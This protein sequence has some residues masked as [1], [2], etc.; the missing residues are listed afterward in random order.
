MAEQ[1]KKL[2]PKAKAALEQY[3]T[4]RPRLERGA[5]WGGSAALLTSVTGDKGRKVRLPATLAATAG[6]MADHRLQEFAKKNREAARIAGDTFDKSAS[7]PTE[8]MTTGGRSRA[9]EA[10]KLAQTL[11][12]NKAVIAARAREQLA[13][14]FPEGGSTDFSGGKSQFIVE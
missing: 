5:K 3:S 2:S 9:V 6:G 7:C 10:A 8:H 12:S 14:L 11:F 1:Q 13:E 4:W